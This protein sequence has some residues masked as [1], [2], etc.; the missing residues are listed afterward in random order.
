MRRLFAMLALCAAAVGCEP[1]WSVQGHAQT[2]AV[3][4]A[5]V[6]AAAVLRCPGEPERSAVTDADGVFEMG[7]TG[8]GPSLD[9]VVIVSAPG[10]ASASVSLRDACEDPVGER[11]S[12]AT[13]EVPL[14][15][16]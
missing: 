3:A 15:A 5:A 12:V 11:C 4:S 8:A 1:S 13:V 6:A 14:A 7:G 16:R 2:A 9:C 10:H